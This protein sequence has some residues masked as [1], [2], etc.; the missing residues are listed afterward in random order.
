MDCS[1]LLLASVVSTLGG[2][3]F[4]YELGII[5]GALLQIKTEFGLSC[6]QQEALVS[7]L[8]TGALLASVAGGCLI[9]RHGRRNSIL[10]SNV[11]VLTG[12]LVLLISSYP[13]LVLGRITVGFAICISSM[14]CCIFVSEMVTPDR[15]G[16]LVTLYEAG[17]TVGILAA[18]AMNY[19]LSGSETGW[20]WMFG[21]AVVP[22]LVQLVSI[23]FLPSNAK[24]SF[25]QR[26][27]METIE[28]QEADDGKVISSKENKA[29][30][31]S[32]FYLFQ[33][34]DNMRTR[35]VI[36][37]GLVLFQQFTGQPN[38]LF[39]ASTIFHS[40]GFESD[41]SAVLASVG[42]GLVKVIATLTSMVFLDRVGRRPLLISS[43]SVMAVCLI[44]IGLLS[45]RS[46]MN[47]M[48][49]CDSQNV[50]LVNRTHLP[51]SPALSPAVVEPPLSESHHFFNNNT[52]DEDQMSN[53]VRQ[54]SPE[55]SPNVHSTVVNWIILMCMM[56]VV[57]GYSAGF[58]PMTWLLLSEIFPA[59][60]RGRAFAFTNCFNWAANL[61]VTFT[62]LNVIDGIG[63]SGI[64]LVYGLT[65]VAAAVF[66]Y[67]MLPETKGKSLEEIDKEL[68]LSRFYYNEECCSFISSRNT[69]PQY[70]RV[71]CQC[72]T[73]G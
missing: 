22:A 29:V 40:V 59:A 61:L 17:I 49:P 24:E 13:A 35:T 71:H 73:S 48:K 50:T 45:G 20:K 33:R 52:K 30:Q 16:F 12:S 51:Q 8:L 64:F 37:L 55:S 68:R 25:S 60:V 26:E 53:K 32:S 3:V 63:L 36:G 43:C 66:F 19:I 31:Y 10:L 1:I 62:F 28:T 14:S 34:H 23:W 44:T 56:A 47:S 70:Q 65:A 67:F 21:L 18:Y 42:L 5:S 9:D 54:A 58:G 15:R 38:V 2:L 57:S 7:S 27:L 69:S 11:L 41:A 4:G 72:S 6:V 46:L 39:Y